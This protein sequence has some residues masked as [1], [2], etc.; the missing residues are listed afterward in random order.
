VV[1]PVKYAPPHV[2]YHTELILNFAVLDKTV[3]EEVPK[4]VGS[5]GAHAIIMEPSRHTLVSMCRITLF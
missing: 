5:A 1:D 4:L 2:R 3:W